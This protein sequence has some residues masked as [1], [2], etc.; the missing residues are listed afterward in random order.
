MLIRRLAIEVDTEIMIGYR[1]PRLS[2]EQARQLARIRLKR[3]GPY[4]LE[5]NEEER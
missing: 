3:V 4:P 5:Q 1:N 2:F